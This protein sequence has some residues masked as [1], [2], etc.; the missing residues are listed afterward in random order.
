MQAI[1]L[2]RKTV[3]L[4]CL[5]DIP[6][7]LCATGVSLAITSVDGRSVPGVTEAGNPCVIE[8]TVETERPA[9]IHVLSRQP[10]KPWYVCASIPASPAKSGNSIPWRI[11]GVDIQRS[12]NSGSTAE[13]C[14]VLL[15]HRIAIGNLSKGIPVGQG[16]TQ[17][18]VVRAR[19]RRNLAPGIRIRTVDGKPAVPG[20]TIATKHVAEVSADM[21]DIPAGATVQIVIQP[22]DNEARW[23]SAVSVPGPDS[24]HYQGTV[25]FGRSGNAKDARDNYQWFWVYAVVVR[26]ELPT[27][28]QGISRAVWVKL[29]PYIL[30]RSEVVRVWRTSD[31]DDFQIWLDSIGGKPIELGRTGT[32]GQGPLSI[33]RVGSCTGHVYVPQG[34]DA[35]SLAVWLLMRPR[36]AGR[37]VPWFRAAGPYAVRGDASWRIP[38][39]VLSSVEESAAHRTWLCIAA[40]TNSASPK[41]GAVRG[42]PMSDEA[43]SHCDAVSEYVWIKPEEH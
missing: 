12:S 18:G 29:Q 42:A 16:V 40:L 30:A 32:M 13:V 36:E 20:R 6:V 38:V 23:A 1:D 37:N 10:G 15:P 11:S 31:P 35:Q 39:A 5:L 7:A 26:K 27:G 19:I 14:C 34:T 41:V 25:F 33:D 9:W 4:I 17:S 43:L 24:L 2:L 3:F 22:V 21:H 8:G 28:N